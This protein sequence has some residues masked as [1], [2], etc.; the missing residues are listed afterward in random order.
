RHSLGGIVRRYAMDDF[1]LVW[2][3]G[4]DRRDTGITPFQSVFSPVEPQARLALCLI[5][6]VTLGA[7]L[8][9]DRLD[10]TLIIDG[11]GCPSTGTGAENEQQ[12][13]G[14]TSRHGAVS[15]RSCRAG[16]DVFRRNGSTLDCQHSL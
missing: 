9:D 16:R 5:H 15:S 10:V 13:G 6:T 4:Y 8:R 2:V 7:M 12:C 11:G 14:K 3:A 1:A